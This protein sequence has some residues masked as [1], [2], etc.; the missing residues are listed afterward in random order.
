VSSGD[1]WRFCIKSSSWRRLDHF[2]RVER[3]LKHE[4]SG[5]DLIVRVCCGST[6]DVALSESGKEGQ[7]LPDIES[8]ALLMR[9]LKTSTE[10][11][12]VMG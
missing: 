4:D 1:C 5:A 8:K 3:R 12:T 7:V 11:L 2:T 9:C 6:F 10:D